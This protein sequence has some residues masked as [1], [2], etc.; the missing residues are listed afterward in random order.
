MPDDTHWP[1]VGALKRNWL[2]VRFCRR[3]V[4][5][6][7]NGIKP[8]LGRIRFVVSP[9]PC[10]S[11]RNRRW[12]PVYWQ[13]L[14]PWDYPTFWRFQAFTWVWYSQR[15]GGWPAASSGLDIPI[16]ARYFALGL[17][18]SALISSR[19][20]H[21]SVQASCVRVSWLRFSV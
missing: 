12:I 14:K 8:T 21:Y 7:L 6:P 2:T 9:K 10:C 18:V 20:G 19:R 4:S 13:C 1:M 5:D 16:I 17:F 11:V 15:F 3:Q